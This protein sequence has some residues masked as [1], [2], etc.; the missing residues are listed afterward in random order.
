MPRKTKNV[1]ISS[2]DAITLYKNYHKIK[3]K[4]KTPANSGVVN[5]LFHTENRT[6]SLNNKNIYLDL[7]RISFL[8]CDKQYS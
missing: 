1:K 7:P 2:Q 8:T 6:E 3:Q 5:S 4:I